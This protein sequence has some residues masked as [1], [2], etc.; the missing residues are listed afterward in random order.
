MDAVAAGGLG[1]VL[2]LAFG[3]GAGV[4]AG[5]VIARLL[6]IR[7]LVPEGH[8]NILVLAL[9]LLLFETCDAW[10]AHSGIMAVT[11]AGVVV[12]NLR[13][14][15]GDAQMTNRMTEHSVD[16]GASRRPRRDAVGSPRSVK[17]QT[18]A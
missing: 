17:A 6:A 12:G 5:F 4:V 2:R 3:A 9:V 11:V 8:Q 16:A 13:T 7:R 10:V 14:P 15:V 18:R 1:L